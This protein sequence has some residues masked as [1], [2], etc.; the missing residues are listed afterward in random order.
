MERI[1]QIR[2]VDRLRDP[3]LADAVSRL[4]EAYAPER[5]YLFGSRARGDVGA[6]SD[7]DLL[8]VVADNAPTERR[9]SQLA[10][11]SLRGTGAAVDILVWTRKDFE[12]R[13]HLNASLPSTVVREGKIL[14]AA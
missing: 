2:G 7:Y 8:I 13:L 1:G 5:I 9:H 12:S 10:Y 4:V 14:Y 3:G 6:D 11:R